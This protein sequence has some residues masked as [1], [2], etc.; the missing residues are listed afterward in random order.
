[1]D[2]STDM[3]ATHALFEALNLEISSGTF[4][5]TKIVL[6]SRR[7]SCTAG[8]GEVCRPKAIYANTHILKIVPY[9]DRC[10]CAVRAPLS[11]WWAVSPRLVLR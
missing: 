6:Y 1:M 10:E 3:T 2:D 7:D 9:F 11:S 8:T 4:V 5:D